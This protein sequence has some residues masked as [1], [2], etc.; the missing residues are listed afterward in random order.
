MRYP[1]AAHRT[2][3]PTGTRNASPGG[4]LS[5]DGETIVQDG[6]FKL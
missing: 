5:A 6:R 4:R 2:A 3:T 1:D